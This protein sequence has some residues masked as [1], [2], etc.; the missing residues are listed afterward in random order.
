VFGCAPAGALVGTTTIGLTG[1]TEIGVL[2]RVALRGQASD[3][4]L[5]D[6]S[7]AQLSASLLVRINLR[8]RV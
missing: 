8:H 2:K 7:V 6:R 4:S 3:I 5:P 1:R